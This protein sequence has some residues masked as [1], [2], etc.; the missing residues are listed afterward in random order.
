MGLHKSPGPDE[1]LAD[2]FVKDLTHCWRRVVEAVGT[3]L[4]GGSLPKQLNITHIALIPKVEDSSSVKDYR[5]INLCNV[6]HKLISK[7]LVSRLWLIMEK[8]IRP[9]QYAFL[10]RRQITNS[11]P[12]GNEILSFIK[13]KRT[14]KK[15]CLQ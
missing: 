1:I 10:S 15:K 11:C 14:V 3:S 2:F 5:P 13:S 12:L 4:H 9:P 6:L 7:C 8:I